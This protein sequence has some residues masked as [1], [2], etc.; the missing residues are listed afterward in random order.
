MATSRDEQSLGSPHGQFVV[1]D[2][3]PPKDPALAGFVGKR[4]A[5]HGAA[6]DL[7]GNRAARRAW[8]K[9]ARRQRGNP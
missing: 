2:G 3:I 7:D 5:V 8:K 6:P 4:R 1:G 9:V